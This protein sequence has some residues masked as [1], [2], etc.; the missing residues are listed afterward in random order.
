MVYYR[1]KESKKTVRIISKNQA[2]LDESTI[3]QVQY[4]GNPRVY[5]YSGER[6][7]KMFTRIE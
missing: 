7:R 4:V 6:F 5:T 1:N 3:I 2:K